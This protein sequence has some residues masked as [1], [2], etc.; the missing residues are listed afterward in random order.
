MGTLELYAV[1][2]LEFILIKTAAAASSSSLSSS[3]PIHLSCSDVRVLEMWEPLKNFYDCSS[4]EVFE[5]FFRFMR[6]V[7]WALPLRLFLFPSS[8][9]ME[10]ELRRKKKRSRRLF[11]LYKI[12]FSLFKYCLV[13]WLNWFGV[14]LSVNV[15]IQ[16]K[17]FSFFQTS[18]LLQRMRARYIDMRMLIFKQP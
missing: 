1:A 11:P 15:C 13:L 10:V 17:F 14:G 5:T 2:S 18:F 7:L 6:Q 8:G 4:F 9:W 12:H 16:F 3:R